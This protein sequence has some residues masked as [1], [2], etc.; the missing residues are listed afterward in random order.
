MPSGGEDSSVVDGEFA[1]AMVQCLGGQHQQVRARLRGDRAH[2]HPA[3]H[4][5]KAPDGHHL[6]WAAVRATVLHADAIDRDV[7]LLGADP[8]DRG[9]QALSVLDLPGEQRDRL[10]A[11]D[12]DPGIECGVCGE[13]AGQ[14]CLALCDGGHAPA[15]RWIARRTRGWVPHRHRCGSSASVISSS[16]GSGLRSSS[17][18]A[19]TTIP[20]VQ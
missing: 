11:V 17:A 10:P 5:R 1:G 13:T 4:H 2:R 7:Q 20:A 12:P 9:A 19:P 8:R 3:L 18:R 14:L 6:A 16:L 15:A